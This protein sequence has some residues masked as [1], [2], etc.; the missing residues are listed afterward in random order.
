MADVYK[1]K[2]K[3]KFLEEYIWRDIEITS[4]SSVAKLG[5]S[6]IVAFEGTAS[7]LFSIH[8]GGNRYEIE[9]FDTVIDDEQVINPVRTKLSALKLDVGDVLTMEYDYG[10]G[11][12]FSI[13]LIS[14]TEMKRGSGTHYPYVTDGKGKGII[15]DMSPFDLLEIIRN[16]DSTESLP[17]IYDI[18]AEREIEWDYR[19]F[20]LKYVNVFFKDKVLRT[21][22]AYE[23]YE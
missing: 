9:F 6:V 18:I 23:V 8:Y 2:V 13:E 12:E 20:D 1:F 19:E 14:I 17:K 22:Y 7:H 11:W 10:A 5:Y 15:E 4:V 3:L 21:Q 16:I